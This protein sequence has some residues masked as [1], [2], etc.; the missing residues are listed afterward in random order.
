MTNVVACGTN[1]GVM[2]KIRKN[3][4]TKPEE[5][6]PKFEEPSATYDNLRKTTARKIKYERLLVVFY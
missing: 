2:K 5:T 1:V 3:S 4:L 6:L